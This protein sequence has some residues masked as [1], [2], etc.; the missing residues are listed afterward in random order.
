MPSCIKKG[1][2]KMKKVHI[3]IFTPSVAKV[4]QY[5]GQYFASV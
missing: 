3:A 2:Y 1:K 5:S 4:D